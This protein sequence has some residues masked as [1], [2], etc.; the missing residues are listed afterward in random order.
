MASEGSSLFHVL[1]SENIE[2][3]SN[4]IRSRVEFTSFPCQW[5]LLEK[6]LAVN[7]FDA[8]L[9]SFLFSCSALEG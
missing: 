4:S 2:D 3:V 1:S 9:Y 8:L 7:S 6:T 5:L